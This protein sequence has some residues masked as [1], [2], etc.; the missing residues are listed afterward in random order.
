MKTV[1]IFLVSLFFLLLGGDNYAYTGAHLKRAKY[2]SAQ[3][4]SKVQKVSLGTVNKDNTLIKQANLSED[5]EHLISVE[6]EDESD[7]LARRHLLLDKYSLLLAY[8]FVL[9]L[10][11]IS[12][13]KRLPFCSHLSYSSSYKYLLQR[14]LRL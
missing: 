11:Y 1:Y 3:D 7:G 9:N 4:V 12:F 2:S 10:F 8:T 5:S 14:S 13:V 6:D